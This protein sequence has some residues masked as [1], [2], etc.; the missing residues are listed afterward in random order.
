MDVSGV[1]DCGYEA[2]GYRSAARRAQVCGQKADSSEVHDRATR[3]TPRDLEIPMYCTQITHSC[4][5]AETGQV[6]EAASG[7]RVC[8]CSGHNVWQP[9]HAVSG[10]LFSRP[11]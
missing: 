6:S 1:E 4:C 7:S 5:F 3:A 2:I 9:E 11:P 10:F 8:R